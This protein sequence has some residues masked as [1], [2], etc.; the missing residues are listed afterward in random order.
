MAGAVLDSGTRAEGSTATGGRNAARAGTSGVR[1]ACLLQMFTAC[2]SEVCG[3]RMRCHPPVKSPA[4]ASPRVSAGIWIAARAASGAMSPKA[5]LAEI[6]S[7][8]RCAVRP[9]SWARSIVMPLPSSKPKRCPQISRDACRTAEPDHGG[10]DPVPP[11]LL[12]LVRE[13]GELPEDLRPV[14]VVVLVD[15]VAEYCTAP[16][17][18]HA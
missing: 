2:R 10:D 15:E 14:P 8:T 5:M 17:S 16:R 18:H 11:L 7:L 13:E 1:S 6:S 9:V 3:A 12:F 4:T